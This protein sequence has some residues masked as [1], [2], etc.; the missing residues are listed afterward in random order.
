LKSNA[1]SPSGP[2][3]LF[4]PERDALRISEYRAKIFS[5]LKIFSHR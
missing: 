1:T 3:T 2:T 4:A 5:T